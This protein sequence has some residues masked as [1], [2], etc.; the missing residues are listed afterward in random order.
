MRNTYRIENGIAYVEL[1]QGQVTRVDADALDT[2]YGYLFHAA[3]IYNAFYAATICPTEKRRLYL[4]RIVTN[5]PRGLEVDHINGD[6]LDNR[7]ENLRLV[8]H[9]LNQKNIGLNRK[10]TSGVKGVY[11]ERTRNKWHAQIS[12]ENR[13]IFL[14]RFDTLEEGKAAYAAASKKYHGEYGRLE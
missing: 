13:I 6:R 14:G 1:T 5:A 12:V 10:N 8:P 2:L 3:F 9:R 4:H 11:W 7:R